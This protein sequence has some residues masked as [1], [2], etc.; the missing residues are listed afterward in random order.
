MNSTESTPWRWNERRVIPRWSA[1]WIGI[2]APFSLLDDNGKP[3]DIKQ[4][5]EKPVLIDFWATWCGQSLIKMKSTD[6]FLRKFPGP[7]VVIAPSRDTELTRAE[8][9]HYLDKMK[10]GF[11]L[12][13]DDEK[14]R[15]IQLPY[16]PARLFLDQKDRLRFMDFGASPT[17]RVMLERKVRSLLQEKR[18]RAALASLKSVHAPTNTHD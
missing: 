5:R 17:G 9:R 7:L 15:Q 18:P 4:Y 11:V 10:Y 8:A 6:A 14:R 3:L 12:V 16:I 1:I 2:W 13:Y